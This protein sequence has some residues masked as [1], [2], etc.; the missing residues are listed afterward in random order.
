MS[1]SVYYQAFVPQGYECVTS[2]ERGGEIV[3]EFQPLRASLQCG[4]CG[5]LKVHVH[6]RRFRGNCSPK[7]WFGTLVS[8]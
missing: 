1:A 8:A 3:V 4:K 5:T 7:V 6:D 2:Y